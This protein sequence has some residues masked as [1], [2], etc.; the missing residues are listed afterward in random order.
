[1]IEPQQIKTHVMTIVRALRK[2]WHVAALFAIVV[3]G[4]TFVGSLMMP[5]SY[6]SEAKVFVRFGRENLTLDPTASNGQLISIYES[7]ESE[8]NSLLEILRS[9]LVLDKVVEMLGP[10]YILHGHEKQIDPET[11][12]TAENST[13][14]ALVS[15]EIAKLEAVVDGI[16]PPAKPVIVV[17][18]SDHQRA[19]LALEKELEIFAPKKSNIIS[20]ACKAQTPDRAQRIV[21]T[22]IAVYMEEHVRVHRTAGSY[23][24]FERQTDQS[25]EQWRRASKELENA[26]NLLKISSIE[27]K[28]KQLEDQMAEI[29]NRLK[30]GTAELAAS[31]SKIRGIEQQIG[32]LPERIETQSLEGPNAAYDGMRTQLFTLEARE[33]ELA[34]RSTDSHPQ[35]I[36][37][38]QQI[39]EL[40]ELLK[41]QGSSRSQPTMSINPARQAL[42]LA[43]HTE[44]SQV[45]WLRGRA[46]S[47]SKQKIALVQDLAA[48]NNAEVRFAQL[49]RQVDLSEQ[50][51]RTYA[52]KLEQAR[53]NRS[54]DEERI[55]SLSIVQPA[56]FVA[57][58]LGPRKLMVLALGA[59]V[60]IVG[61][62]GLAVIL[63]YFFPT[64]VA[65]RDLQQLGVPMLGVMPSFGASMQQAGNAPQFGRS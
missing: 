22:M 4:L 2:R 61:G 44:Q 31:E 65:L 36:A 5:R 9:R 52:E 21:A 6:F 55:S 26:K 39:A 34:A 49:Q 3:M 51:H 45:N 17:P 38:R 40:R 16:R 19:V 18:S 28:R 43:L 13:S 64:L 8:I 57:K 46:Q 60:A 10:Q 35:L 32:K 25:L 47:L 20:V 7:R 63:D 12:L 30:Q 56:T 53:I 27:G 59:F 58:P 37:V 41:E 14:D 29:E 54:L 15:S 11:G 24:F 1:M 42:E 23:E 48:L 62:F 50:R 33:F